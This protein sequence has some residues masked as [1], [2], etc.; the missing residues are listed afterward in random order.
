MKDVMPELFTEDEYQ[1]LIMALA[2]GRGE[3]GFTEAEAVK[4]SKWAW[5]I[6]FDHGLLGLILKG[7]VLVID[8]KDDGEPVLTQAKA[9]AAK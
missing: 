5:R 9:E 1:S 4:L 6:R 3:K 8:L 2:N 7:K